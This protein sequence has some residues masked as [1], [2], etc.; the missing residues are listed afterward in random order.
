MVD[1]REQTEVEAEIEDVI[2]GG[3]HQKMSLAITEAKADIEGIG[4]KAAFDPTALIA[5]ITAIF[6]AIQGCRTTAGD[7][8]VT[9][10]E[11]PRGFAAYVIRRQLAK[12]FREND[13][14][15]K[16]ARNWARATVDAMVDADHQDLFDVMEYAEGQG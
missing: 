8:V 4:I 5:V 1:W 15:R 2:E 7:R 11:R 14:T 16:D 10:R 9:A 6:E 3:L 13:A 12:R